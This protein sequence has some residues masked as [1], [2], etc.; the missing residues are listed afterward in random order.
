MNLSLKIESQ[1]AIY[2]LNS[3]ETSVIL[4]QK[5]DFLIDNNFSWVSSVNKLVT[6]EI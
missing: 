1:A 6:I 4:S 3:T 2:P 5:L